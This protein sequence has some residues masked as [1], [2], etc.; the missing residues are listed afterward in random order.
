M[1]SSRDP[2]QFTAY[3]LTVTADLS[4]APHFR[5]AHPLLM[6]L[7]DQSAL[8]EDLLTRRYVQR[9]I[10]LEE[11]H[12]LQADLDDLARHD[13]KILNSRNVIDAKLDPDDDIFINHIVFPVRP[14]A[15]TRTSTRLICVPASR[16]QFP[17]RMLGNIDRMVRKLRPLEMEAVGVCQ[18][19][20]ERRDMNLISHRLIVDSITNSSVLNLEGAIG[21]RIEI[22]TS[23]LLDD[24][25]VHRIAHTVGI[26]VFVHGHSVGFIVDEAIRVA[27]EHRVD[28]ER[29]DMLVMRG[30]N[31]WVDNCAEGDANVIKFVVDGLGGEDPGCSH[32]VDYFA[33]LIE[34]ECQDVLIVTDCDDALEH[35]FA[36]PHYSGTA[37][38]IL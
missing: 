31:S 37:S 33:C 36:V 5:L 13:W 6:L 24:C 3:R 35:E 27:V 18:H 34:H 38:A 29:E 15:H 9:R 22:Q 14:R 12:R 8:V 19:F 10:P 1:A 21:V 2:S 4:F 17:I 16:V 7:R 26:P 28:S 11:I 25:F 32:F 23:G 30:Q 20:L